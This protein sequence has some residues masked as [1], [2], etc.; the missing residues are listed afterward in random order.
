MFRIIRPLY[1]S[2][3]QETEFEALAH[4]AI[5]FSDT[6]VI[7]I[8]GGTR[9]LGM[10]CARHLATRHGIRQFVLTGK[11]PFPPKEEWGRM[12]TFSEPVQEKIK[13]IQKLQQLGATVHVTAFPLDDAK[14]LKQQYETVQATIGEIT[15]IIHAAG[16][17]DI[18]NPA[19]IRKPV[20][21]LRRVTSPKVEGLLNLIEMADPGKLQFVILFSSVSAIIPG[22]GAGQS[23]YAMA[24]AFMDYYAGIHHNRLPIVSIQWPSWKETGMGEAKNTVYDR[25]GLLSI[26]NSEG[27]G[28]LDRILTS[29]HKPVVMPVV[30]DPARFE[31]ETLLEAKAPAAPPASK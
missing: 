1:H 3:L 21:T 27:L 6:D 29:P 8:T 9:G 7:L 12:E 22:L 26:L 15:G 23:D 20:S 30:A 24:N 11:T 17:M 10:L 19:F 28:F 14:E 4:Q 16:S 31:P 13:Q 25:S 5:S 2:F 18:E